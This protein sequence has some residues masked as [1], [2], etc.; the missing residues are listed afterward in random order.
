MGLGYSV[1]G[2]WCIRF[3]TMC[4]FRALVYATAMQHTASRGGALPFFRA[5]HLLSML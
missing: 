3:S 1:E 4:V 5:E 2:L